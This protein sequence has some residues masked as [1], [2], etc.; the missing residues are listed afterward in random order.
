MSDAFVGARVARRVPLYIV[1]LIG[2]SPSVLFAQTPD[3][4]APSPRPAWASSSSRPLFP[5]RRHDD[6]GGLHF[7]HPIFT[8]SVSP[9]TKIRVDFANAFATDATESEIEVEGEY[10]L[11]RG[12]SIEVTAPYAIV[13]PDVG[14]TESDLGNVEVALKFANFNFE[15]QGVLLGYGVEFGLPTGSAS[16]GIGSDHI[17]EISPY[18]NIGYQRGRVELV[19]WSIFQIPTH[20]NPTEEVE[21]EFRYDFSGLVHVTDRFEGLLELNGLVGLSGADA[22][23]GILSIAPGFKVAPLP[24]EKLFIGLGVSIPFSS[25]EL[26]AQVRSSVFWHF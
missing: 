8:E 2:L 6:H 24:T 20:Q 22:G 14:S 18:L 23:N 10:A 11:H 5:R 19:G 26:D 12:F 3:G 17:W 1:L 21:T 15:E 7:S 13:N 9:D 16:S 4:P 25:D